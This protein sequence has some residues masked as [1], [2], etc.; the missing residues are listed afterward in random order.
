MYTRKGLIN[1]I[2]GIPFGALIIPL[3]GVIVGSL[4][5]WILGT[6]MAPILAFLMFPLVSFIIFQALETNESI[7]NSIAETFNDT[8]AYEQYKLIIGGVAGFFSGVIAANIYAGTL[9]QLPELLGL[10]FLPYAIIHTIYAVVA[11]YM[12]PDIRKYA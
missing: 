12:A 7:Q 5:D 8:E 9:G 1:T 4:L 3:P 11:A 2:L 10:G 6:H